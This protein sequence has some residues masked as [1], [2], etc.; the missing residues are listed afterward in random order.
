[1]PKTSMNTIDQLSIWH[2]HVC[3]CSHTA[4]CIVI[5]HRCI[6][7]NQIYHSLRYRKR[8][9]TISYFVQYSD[10]CHDTLFG[11]IE[12]FFKNKG[13]T[14]ALIHNYPNRNLFSDIFS[15]SS[16]HSFLS[17]ST[18]IYF[19]QSHHCS[20][21]YQWRKYQSYALYLKKT[22]FLLRPLFLKLLNMI[23]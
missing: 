9:S 1:M 3:G 10:D 22:N 20:I 21:M 23:K 13:S 12:V 18:F 5:Y 7:K 8:Q 2:A 6:I 19:N 4:T 15:S 14:F 17:I 16:Y 11:S